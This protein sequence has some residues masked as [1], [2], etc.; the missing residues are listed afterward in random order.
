MEPIKPKRTTFKLNDYCQ[1]CYEKVG[2]KVGFCL[3]CGKKMCYT[4]TIRYQVPICED[5][6]QKV[7]CQYSKEH[8]MPHIDITVRLYID[9]HKEE[10]TD[11]DAEEIVSN[12]DYHFEYED[13]NKKIMGTQIM[14]RETIG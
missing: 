5:C 2:E 9:S 12:C 4:C 11:E 14:E 1:Q 3:E 13:E 8:Q 7:I 6:K 10:F